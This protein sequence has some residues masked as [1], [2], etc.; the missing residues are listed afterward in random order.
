[1][2]GGVGVFSLTLRKM[3]PRPASFALLCGTSS[4][5]DLADRP[6]SGTRT[7]AL[8]QIQGLYI[9]Q[10]D[11]T[12]PSDQHQGNP[13]SILGMIW[14]VCVCVFEYV[15]VYVCEYVSMVCVFMYASVCCV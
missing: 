6:R 8:R 3:L 15:Y 13:V 14:C 7:L 11:K 1:M 5:A 2:K 4:L 9:Q 10:L 12:L